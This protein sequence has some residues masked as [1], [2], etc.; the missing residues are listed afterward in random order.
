MEKVEVSMS[1]RG[2]EIVEVVFIKSVRG[3]IGV[4][5]GTAE[6]NGFDTFPV[7]GYTIQG[8]Q[9]A[10]LALALKATT[11]GNH[12]VKGL[13]FTYT[14]LGWNYKFAYDKQF[15]GFTILIKNTP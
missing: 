12:T 10:E 14:Y 1:D 3:Q 2:L 8:G 13:L 11:S 5:N 9:N 7:K 4:I 6:E 15:Q